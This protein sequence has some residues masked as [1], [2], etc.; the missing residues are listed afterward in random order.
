MVNLIR[1][2]LDGVAMKG[3]SKMR[4]NR[5]FLV[6][7]SMILTTLGVQ[8]STAQA[9]AP[10]FR[11]SSST[12][13]NSP[14]PSV[15]IPATVQA[16]DQLVMV[17][18]TNTN[19]TIDTPAGWNL[20]GTEQ[21]ARP[22]GT[23][24][25]TSAVFATTADG[26]TAGSTVGISLGG[27]SKTAITVVAY[28]DSQPA[29][30]AI[31][32][33]IDASSLSLT[34]APVTAGQ[35]DTVVISY[36]VDKGSNTGWTAPADV[37]VRA[38]SIGSGGGRVTA[39][40]GDRVATAGEVPG[41]TATSTAGGT[42][43]IGWTIVLDPVSV[44]NVA[45]TAAVSG[46]CVNL[47]CTFDA[48]ASADGDGAIVRFD[49]DFGDGTVML[50]AGP[51]PEH[52]YTAASD[53][54]VTVTVTDNGGLDDDATVGVTTTDGPN[55]APTASFT[56]DCTFLSC[57][58]DASA[59]A[60]GDGTVSTYL[61]N[62]GDGTP[63][64][65]GAVNP[66]HVFGAAG[67]YTVTLIVTDND[68]ADSAPAQVEAHPT[69][70]PDGTAPVFRASSSNNLNSSNPSVV[71]PGA[72]QSGDQ[73]VLVVS[74]NT[75]APIQT[76]AGWDLIGFQLDGA[77]VA[78]PNMSSA[79]FTA[80]ADGDSA[81]STVNATI[82]TYSKTAMTLV[83][84][85]GALPAT[86]AIA[87]TIGASSASLTTAPVTVGQ[88]GT[89]V[90]SY[91]VDKG[92]NTGWTAPADVDVRAISIGSG[93][94]RVTALMGDRVAIAGE[95]PGATATSTSA[96]SKGIA[97]T[98]ALDPVL[99]PNVAPTASFTVDCTYLSCEFDATGSSDSDGTIDTYSWD[100]GDGITLPDGDAV[101]THV[102]T[103]GDDYDVSL[104][105]TDDDLETSPPAQMVANAVQNVAPVAVLDAASCVDLTCSFDASGS[106]DSV[107]SIVSYDWD[108]GDGPVV[109]DA[110]PT[111]E[112]VYATADDF[113][114]TVTVT[115]DGGLDDDASV[116][117]TTTEPPNVAP[118]A[119]FTVDCTYLSCEFDATG[120]SDSDG[121][122]DTYSWDFDDGITIPAGDTVQT[123]VY[124]AGGN[125]DVSLIVTDDDL[126]TS[127][128]AQMV[129]NAVQNV[130]P[131]AVLDPA[132]C[133]DLTCSFDASGSTDSV[134]SIVTYDW[135]FGDGT[136]VLDAGSTPEHVYATA[137]NFT[138]TVTVTDD[139]GLD[140]AA[141]VGVTTT[142]PPNAAPTASFTVD[143]TF[144]SCEFDATGSSDSDGTIGTYNWDF[145]DGTPVA[146]GPVNPTH[147]YATNGEY[148]VTLVVTDDEGEPSAPAQMT[149]TTNVSPTAAFTFDCVE[150]ACTFDAT[151]SVDSD[152]TIESYD[153]D[154]GDGTLA[155]D[156]GTAPNH[157]YLGAA[158]YSVSLTVT[159]DQGAT[160]SVTIV[161][162]PDVGPVAAFTSSCVDLTC[163]FN[164]SASNEP[165]GTI[166]TYD[167]VFDGTPMPDAG[168]TPEF[169][170]LFGGT[171]NVEL[172]VTDDDGDDAVTGGTVSP[173]APALPTQ[174]LP[175]DVPR[176]NVP[177]IDTGEITD[178]ELIGNRVYIVG[179]FSSIRNNVGGNNTTVNQRWLAAYNIDTGLVDTTFRPTF[180]SGVT[181][182]VRSPDGSRLY[183]VGRFNTVNGITRR[184]IA[185][186][187]PVTGA[188]ITQFSA[189]AS[190]AA[191]AVAATDTTVYVGG[192]FTAVRNTE[193][194]GL[195][196]VDAITGA[197]ET[198]FVNN[199]S[200]GIGVDGLLTVQAMD[201]APDGDTLLVVHTGRQING[202]DRYG[203]ALIDTGTN[204]LLPWRSRLWDDNLARVGGV[205]RI[206]A[207]AIAPNGEYF[208]VSSGSG[209][210]RPPISDTVVAYPINGGDFV[211]PLWVSRMF[212]SVY[213]LAISDDAIFTGGHMN[214]VESQTAPD[215]WPGLD[216]AGYG[217]GQGLAGY[218]LGDDIVIRNHIA[219]ID[220]AN[221]KAIEWNPGSNSFE[222]NKAMLWTERGLFT[223]G[224]A[225]TQGG[226]N[227]GR[228]AFYDL[229]DLPSPSQTD[230]FIT[231]P[232]EGRVEK[233]GEPFVIGGIATATSG[234]QRVQI[235]VFDGNQYL[236]DDL[237]TWGGWNAIIVSD[238][239]S[240]GATSTAWA[241]YLTVDDNRAIRVL[242]RAW[243]NNGTSDP[244]KDI[245]QF[246]TFGLADETPT[247]RI[248][249]PFGIIPTLD[250]TVTGSATDDVGVQSIR[251]SLRDEQDRYI[252]DDGTVAAA[253]NT[254]ST[255]PDV[256]GAVNATWS[257]EVTVPY[258]G[259]WSMQAIAVDTSGQS[260]LRS[261]DRTWLVSATAI[262]PEVA[263][264]SP[265]TV[266]PP[267]DETFVV[268]PGS[269]LTLTGIA[270]DDEGLRNVEVRLRNLITDEN[271]ASD[272][273]W[274]VGLVRRWYR[275]SPVDISGTSYNWTYT[276]PFTLDQGRY[277]FEIRATDD[278]GLTT[279]STFW[280]ELDV[281]VEI[282]GD[283][284]PDARLDVTGT[285]TDIDVLHL[286]LTGTATDDFGV[287]DL[288]FEFRDL[289]T[290]LYLLADGTAGGARTRL[291]VTSI[292][293]T[294]PTSVTFLVSVDLPME[295]DWNIEVYAYDTSGQIDTS[296]SGASARYQIFPGDLA[297]WVSLLAPPAGTVFNDARLIISGRV[298]D[299]RQ[300]AGAQ[301]AIQN[302]TGQYMSASGTF[303]GNS[304]NWR[305]TFLNSPGSLGSNFAYTSP[306]IPDG[307][308]TIYARGVDQRGA[309]TEVP[310]TT[311]ATVTSPPND[312]PVADFTYSCDDNV[313]TFDG[314][315]STDEN[316]STLGYQ[317]S[318]GNGS[319]SGPLPTRTY[320]A[321]GVYTVTLTVTD[322]YG[323][324]AQYSEDVTI[325]T[326]AGNQAPVPVI[327]AASCTLLSCNFS[328]SGTADPD[329]GDSY[330]LL[331]DFG[332]VTT[333]TSSFPSHSFAEPGIYTVTL[334]VTDGWGAQDFLTVIVDLSVPPGNLAPVP[335]I[336]P[337]V[338]DLLSCQFSSAGSS[339]PNAGDTFTV[340]WVFD[341]NGATSTSA[342]PTHVFSAA[343]QYTVELTATDVWGASTTVTLE[344]AV[345]DV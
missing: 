305:G 21:D 108:F 231:S 293:A 329:V 290:G 342:S 227:V 92:S 314:R 252:Q 209:G 112:H 332:D 76:P 267:F 16:G 234:V 220:P 136:V 247:T 197:L 277:E 47:T 246:E 308:Y 215:P 297:P 192:Q 250:F 207:G 46:D 185:A 339:D 98:I 248:S 203:M 72:V 162:A 229:D 327:A 178:L 107:G 131:V 238:L 326:P 159:D 81:G 259:E 122:I 34:T 321:E 149:V 222:G 129:A 219:A 299:D 57:E 141:S 70:A 184:K 12:N 54:D 3:G 66:T 6:V 307:D 179:S 52:V 154:F 212:D 224:D 254:F 312:P 183:V 242:A 172:T 233:A 111:P 163:M 291:P 221:G 205:T 151:G 58:F 32:T 8:A 71:I 61:W 213:S 130:A 160:G 104:V 49:W 264:T 249:A 53:F 208:V 331:W 236:Q 44:A 230:T 89:V 341:D 96:G 116:G 87:T 223:G 319:G 216:N 228:V 322:Y 36:W 142:E 91:W 41:A 26:S 336:N 325:V 279:S 301:V 60:D 175:P 158:D 39:L 45:P 330:S 28:A 218:G 316:T 280:A 304:P 171:Y 156:A 278:L 173:V 97:W 169:A 137:D 286:D 117:V 313:C 127:A 22:G 9:A 120:S 260:D 261:A 186:I 165:N 177:V 157:D 309:V 243:G 288:R 344:V 56:V 274:G 30:T 194:I 195:V 123:H 103:V 80:T 140:D 27:I 258:E 294:D 106:T 306:P 94:G 335:V 65:D 37:D 1:A 315:T 257:Y 101:Q 19:T 20:L 139:G 310:S 143:C 167:W 69:E 95:V 24:D 42:K 2:R 174:Q 115:D 102:Y 75:T 77:T 311:T 270:T 282:E 239:E 199:L 145:G 125:Y 134:G 210:D 256:I 93:G 181:E 296:Q 10:V 265:I 235:E 283:S 40:M 33:T 73:M 204:Q 263:I 11:A 25:M 345:S 152:G 29:T 180:D 237:A 38:T 202:Q 138:V 135:D 50:D 284:P 298:E 85:A 168:A 188:T 300:I 292:D 334:T 269:P 198:S 18:S 55:A 68:D 214:Y 59:S 82:G 119:S 13:V 109:L 251:I 262:R 317:W 148:T 255:Q 295:G 99:V 51:T 153:W 114:V 232:I 110:G 191:T 303:T 161:V 211:E 333:S 126:E 64:A 337:N 244:V 63:P 320:T 323:L 302:S 31:A 43:G 17:V 78:T 225:T 128:P 271:L 67:D 144:L 86:T 281:D 124:T 217:R 4:R 35:D 189:N 15:N 146:D 200:G 5:V 285:I 182:I 74:T 338:C 253:Y 23:P 240:P 170:F 276:T 83:A 275:I 48:S 289:D 132:S 226:Y 328:S 324:A 268:A 62:F 193:R 84:Y 155:P 90:I 340:A 133:V 318:F 88:N 287:A 113:T 121:T 196:A 14:N 147:L 166:A 150:L 187:D 201:I 245:Q 241:Q 206:Y 100:F 164:A 176:R 266:N 7:L 272:G 118:T 343:G 190:S 273:S 79:V 105:V